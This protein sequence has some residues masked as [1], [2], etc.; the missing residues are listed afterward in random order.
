MGLPHLLGTMKRV[1]FDSDG[2][3]FIVGEPIRIAARVVDLDFQPLRDH[4]ITLVATDAEGT[5]SHEFSLGAEAEREGSYAGRIHLAE[6]TW[7]VVVRGLE[8]EDNLVLD[9]AP[10]QWEYERTALDRASLEALAEAS[11][12]SYVTLADL[13]QLAEMV[14]AKTR[15]A[16]STN[17]L[18]LWDTWL[19]LLLL[20]LLWTMEWVLRKRSDLA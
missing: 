11:G 15:K 3:N 5:T 4:D 19:T 10:P 13:P 6:G 16:R 17:E 2:R 12:G 9:V 8:E 20:A 18:P 14:A 7:T 1:S